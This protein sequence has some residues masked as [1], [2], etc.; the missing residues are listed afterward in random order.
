MGL[1]QGMEKVIFKP[2]FGYLDQIPHVV[3]WRDLLEDPLSW[4]KLFLPRQQVEIFALATK[5][6]KD[7]KE[8]TPG[9]PSETEEDVI[10]LPPPYLTPKTEQ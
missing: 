5:K 2:K 7:T 6:P 1:V 10:S 4:L 3:V 8:E 9:H